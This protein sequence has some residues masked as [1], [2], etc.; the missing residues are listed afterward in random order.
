MLNISRSRK[1]FWIWKIRL[2]TRRQIVQ[3]VSHCCS[4]TWSQLSVQLL[5]LPAGGLGQATPL[6]SVLHLA[7]VTWEIYYHLP[8]LAAGGLA[9]KH[10]QQLFIIMK[11]IRFGSNITKAVK[12]SFLKSHQPSES[13]HRTATKMQILK[14]V[15]FLSSGL[16]FCSY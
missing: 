11:F 6:P 14:N 13:F 16:N 10:T 12:T 5:P 1:Y 8:D 2:W 4:V 9:E 15:W 7:S 3:E